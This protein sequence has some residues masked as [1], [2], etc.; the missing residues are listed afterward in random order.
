MI[1]VGDPV[2]AGLV[3]SL[4]RPGG[5]I[6]D[7]TVLSPDLGPKRLQLLREVIA[8]V[9]RVVYLANPDLRGS[10]WCRDSIRPEAK[11]VSAGSQSRAIDTC[12]GCSSPAP[13]LSF[14]MPVSTARSGPGSF[15]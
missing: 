2:R 10:A 15:V 8:N 4:A 7:N 14:A 13:W 6:T 9:K 11:R 5:N 1:G 12:A 3:A